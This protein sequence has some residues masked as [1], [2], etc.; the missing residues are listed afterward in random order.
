MRDLGTLGGTFSRAFGVNGQGQVVGE[1]TTSNGSTRAFIWENGVMRK[2]EALKSVFSRAHAIN[3][4]GTIVGEFH[5]PGQK[6]HAFQVKN[7][8][9]TDLGTFGGNLSLALA[10]NNVGTVAGWAQTAS[11]GPHLFVY[12]NGTKSDLGKLGFGDLGP[13]D[14]IVANRVAQDGST[15]V[16]LRKNGVTTD[17]GRGSGTGINGNEW[18][19]GRH[20]FAGQVHAT[21]WKPS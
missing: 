3:N 13:L 10:V 15:D 19:V 12:R 9:L 17:L 21:L 11:G 1:S 7:G 18:I 2:V 6:S 16:V 8:V 4:A 14:Q 20:D 5:G